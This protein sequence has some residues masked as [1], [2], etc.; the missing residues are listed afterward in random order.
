MHRVKLP[1]SLLALALLE[2]KR[3]A[4]EFSR[5]SEPRSCKLPTCWAASSQC[6]VPFT[7]PGR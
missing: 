4:C 6:W 5:N 2:L 7:S 1:A 3:P